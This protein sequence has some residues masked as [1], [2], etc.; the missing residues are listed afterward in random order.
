MTQLDQHSESNGTTATREVLLEARSCSKSYVAEG[1]RPN[2]SQAPLVLDCVQLAIHAGEFVA[3]LG[4]SGSGK[5]TLL[6]ILAGLIPPSSG[7]VT[8]NGQPLRGTNPAVA[9]VFQSFALY[10]WLTVYENV[11][12]G[13]LAKSL[14]AADRRTRVLRA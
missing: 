1:K 14:P 7:Q 13:L 11:E 8:V 3:L 6:R 9:M 4:P 10:P 2:N 12:L 5:S